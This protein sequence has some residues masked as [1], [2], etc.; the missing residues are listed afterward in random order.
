MMVNIG[1]D[2]RTFFA[3]LS[4][5]INFIVKSYFFKKVKLL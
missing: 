3:D 1:Q 4:A 5:F 2:F